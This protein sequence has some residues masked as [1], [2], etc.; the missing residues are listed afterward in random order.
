M[1]L[2]LVPSKPEEVPLMVETYFEAFSQDPIHQRFA[3][4]GTQSARDF[5]T[6]SLSAEIRDENNHFLSVWDDSCTPETFVGFAKW[7]VPGASPEA[8]PP[9]DQW[10]SEG[11]QQ[12]SVFFF[13]RLGE[14]HHE[15]MGK[16]PHWYL[17]LV[18]VKPQ[19]QGK[20]AASLMLKYGVNKADEDKVECFL[21][22]S[23]A[24]QP[25]YE[26]Y[27]FRVAQRDTFLDGTY[28]QCAMVRD[29]RV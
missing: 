6:T 21:D 8:L 4:R 12:F 9:A 11:D 10:P 5:W 28:I 20:G 27:G 25:I 22:A 7:I 15:A 29:A 17:E 14:M 24:G 3:P 18:A 23:P 13:G 16:R 26:R 19:Y 1:P 2:R